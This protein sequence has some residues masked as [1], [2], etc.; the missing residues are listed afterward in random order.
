MILGKVKKLLDGK[1]KKG[2]KKGDGSI[3]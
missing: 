2:Q 1:R 3:F